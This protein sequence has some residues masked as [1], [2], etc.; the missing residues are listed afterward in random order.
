MEAVLII[1]RCR[2]RAVATPVDPRFA[3]L[4]LPT[5]MVVLESRIDPSD[6]LFQS[7]RDHLQQLVDELAERMARAREGGGP[8][9]LQRHVAQGKLPVRERIERLLDRGLPFSRALAARGDRH[10]RRRGARSRDC[11]RRRPRVGTRGA[12]RRQRRHGQGR[13]LLPDDRQEA[14]AR[15]ADRA[16]QPA[17]VRLSRRFRRRVPAASGRS[18]P[19]PRAL[20]P[21]LLQSGPHVGRTHPADRRGHGLV[22]RGRRIRARHVRR[23]DHRQGHRDHLSGGPAARQGGHGRG[24]HRRGARRSRRAHAVLGGRRLSG[25]RRRPCARAVP[26]GGFDPP[27]RQAAACGCDDAGRT[28]VRPGRHLRHRQRRPSQAV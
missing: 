11:D 18:L 23:N 28:E 14:R 1:G 19:G 13:D 24:S 2:S 5:E 17:A 16:R 7:N 22:H 10:V 8:K 12:D 9:Y 3:A 6:P 20:R 21:H 25:R 26:N 4:R 27:H 15:A